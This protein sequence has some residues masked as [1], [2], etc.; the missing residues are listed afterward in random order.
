MST[1][2][3][4][5]TSTGGTSQA[6]MARSSHSA[7]FP[8]ILI[9]FLSLGL[10]LVR[11]RRADLGQPLAGRR[12]PRLERSA[13]PHQAFVVDVRLGRRSGAAKILRR[14][15]PEIGYRHSRLLC[16]TRQDWYQKG[17]PPVGGGA[18]IVR[19]IIR[20]SWWPESH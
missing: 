18:G 10:V 6:F 17:A 13:E 5:G 4:A 15:P 7:S 8:A 9:I 2:R 11:R 3:A 14:H 19:A 12:R 20:K 16:A 1:S